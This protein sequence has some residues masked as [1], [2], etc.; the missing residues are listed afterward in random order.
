MELRGLQRNGVAHIPFIFQP[1]VEAELSPKANDLVTSFAY[2]PDPMVIEAEWQ[3]NLPLVRELE[4]IYANLKHRPSVRL[5]PRTGPN[6]SD[7]AP[8]LFAIQH[9]SRGMPLARAPSSAPCF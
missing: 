3:N 5:V 4:A 6:R 8:P 2:L 1:P 7:L 9:R